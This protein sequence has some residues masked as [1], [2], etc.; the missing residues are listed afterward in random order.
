MGAAKAD[1]QLELTQQKLAR[2]E[3]QQKNE[4]QQKSSKRAEITKDVKHNT[5]SIQTKTLT[6]LFVSFVTDT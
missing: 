5:M 1:L 4:K 6:F 3:E 2:A